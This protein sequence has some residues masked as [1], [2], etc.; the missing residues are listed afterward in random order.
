VRDLVLISHNGDVDAELVDVSA[1]GVA[2]VI[3]RPLAVDTVIRAVLNVQGG[4][5][6]TVA[7]VRQVSSL[8]C[9]YRVGCVFTEISDANRAR[10]GRHAATNPNDRRTGSERAETLRG[11]LFLSE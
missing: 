3:D 1:D 11:R 2:F 10:L 8:E 7:R 6:P 5:I 4:V 9:G